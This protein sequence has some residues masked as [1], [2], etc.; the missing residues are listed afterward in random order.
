MVEIRE[1]R[2]NIWG[3][4]LDGK[5]VCYE[6]GSEYKLAP[7]FVKMSAGKYVDE[8]LSDIDDEWYLQWMRGNAVDNNDDFTA[9][10]AT[11]RLEELKD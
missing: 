11:L 5:T 9:L 4:C 10:C 1:L 7:K 2:G 8:P 6:D 3:W